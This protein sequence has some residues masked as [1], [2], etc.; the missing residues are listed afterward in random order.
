MS[1]GGIFIIVITALAFL[2]YPPL[3]IWSWRKHFQEK[4][5]EKAAEDAEAERQRKQIEQKFKQ[6]EEEITRLREHVQ[7]LEDQIAGQR[8]VLPESS[9]GDH[10]IG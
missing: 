6:S 7:Q 4:A 8:R 2:I 9:E 10:G 5:A 3:L 1:A